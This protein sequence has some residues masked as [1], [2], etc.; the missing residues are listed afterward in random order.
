MSS[1][2]S[3]PLW[4]EPAGLAIIFVLLSYLQSSSRVISVCLQDVSPMQPARCGVRSQSRVP[5]LRIRPASGQ[6]RCAGVRHLA[7]SVH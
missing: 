6:F 4:R 2:P 5:R 3:T 7:G 1:A